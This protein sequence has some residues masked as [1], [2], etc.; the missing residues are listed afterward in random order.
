LAICVIA[1]DF[2]FSIS[3]YISITLTLSTCIYLGACCVSLALLTL[4]LILA[5]F[6][7]AWSC[8][9]SSFSFLIS[10][11]SGLI[12]FYIIT[13]MFTILGVLCILFIGVAG[14]M[15]EVL[16]KESIESVKLARNSYVF[17]LSF[18]VFCRFY[19]IIGYEI[20]FT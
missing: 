20:I 11:T 8:L 1:I 2:V 7:G 17:S 13:F 9:I 4:A 6:S 14:M 16:V 5:L 18:S 3:A 15:L 19:K 12:A 10:T